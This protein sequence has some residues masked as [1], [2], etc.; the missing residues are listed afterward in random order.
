MTAVRPIEAAITASRAAAVQKSSPPRPAGELAATG[1]IAPLPPDLAAL[2]RSCDG[3]ALPQ[4]DV[5]DLGDFADVNGDSTLFTEL[6]EVVFFAS[7]RADGFFLLDP[8][9]TL[10]CDPKAVYWADRGVLEPDACRKVAYDLASFLAAAAKGAALTDGP[11]IGVISLERLER[12]I[13]AHPAAAETRV[14]FGDV[15]AMLAARHRD[16]PIS[17]ALIDFYALYDGLYL[18]ELKLTVFSLERLGAISTAGSVVA[19][20]FGRDE[21]GRCYGL[22]IGGWRGLPANRLFAVRDESELDS[23]ATLGRFTDVL[24]VWIE[25]ADHGSAR[26]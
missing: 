2:Y 21:G 14:G 20:W 8:N 3:L 24:R 17:F 13:T 23:T 7:D 9:D 25:T 11:E 1:R 6:P 22:T 16:L 19:L 26:P 5:F 15:E 12:A 4:V 10:G 18:P